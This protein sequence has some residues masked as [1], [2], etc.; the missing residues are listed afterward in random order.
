[1]YVFQVLITDTP[2]DPID[3]SPRFNG[4]SKHKALFR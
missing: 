1:M 2:I 3:L 4:Y